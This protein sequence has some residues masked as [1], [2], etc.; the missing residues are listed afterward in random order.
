MGAKTSKS[1]AEQVGRKLKKPLTYYKPSER[2]QKL[3]EKEKTI[4][5]RAPM[6]VK[7]IDFPPEFRSKKLKEIEELQAKDDNY[8]NLMK[9]VKTKSS[10][11]EGYV[12]PDENVHSHLRKPKDSN[13]LHRL[14]ENVKEQVQCGPPKG[15]ASIQDIVSAIEHHKS[16]PNEWTPSALAEQ[17][18]IR[19]HDM[20]EI[21]KFVDL[22]DS[23]SLSNYKPPDQS[24]NMSR[25][26]KP[27]NF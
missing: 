24:D 4:P 11:P 20:A 14:K 3:I 18:K 19:E 12:P 1:V 6:N 5:K 17:I 15:I 26:N 16:D 22:F 9:N 21:L 2:A 27:I 13:I 8:L 10:D 25:L 23:K 7:K